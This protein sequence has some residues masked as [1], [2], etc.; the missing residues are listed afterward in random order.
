MN[1]F[2]FCPKC[3]QPLELSFVDHR[4]RS[5]CSGCG[6]IHYKNPAP[7][8]GVLLVENGSIL[9]VERKF[10]PRKG[11]WSIPAGFLES[12]ED[13]T[14]C[15]VREMKEETNLDVT[16]T[17][18]FNVYSAFDDPRTVAVLVLYLGKRTGG[19]LR[20]GDD[21]SDARYFDLNALPDTM[22][23]RV[24]ARA[25]GDLRELLEGDSGVG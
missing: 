12:D 8:A 4:E 14:E 18:L 17:R 2:H 1:R 22:A 23:F 24:H 13:I 3:G 11:L 21:A 10:E 5:G 9:L 20:C 16:L 25:L 15:A 7:A 6:F 19:T